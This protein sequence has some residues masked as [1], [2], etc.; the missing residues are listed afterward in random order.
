VNFQL[1]YIIAVKFKVIWLLQGSDVESEQQHVEA[2][3]DRVEVLE[4][5]EKTVHTSS[6]RGW[7]SACF[8]CIKKQLDNRVKIL[9]LKSLHG[10]T[11]NFL[12]IV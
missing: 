2:V 4:E 5:V 9:F 6:F 7:V 12:K 3:T 8:L 10:A 11:N 1:Q